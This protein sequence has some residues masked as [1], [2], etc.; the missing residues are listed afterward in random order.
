[1]WYFGPLR[2]PLT[3]DHINFLFVEETSSEACL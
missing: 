2:S 1:M 3:L